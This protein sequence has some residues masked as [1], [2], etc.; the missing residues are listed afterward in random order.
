MVPPSGPMRGLP[1]RSRRN[2]VC[3]PTVPPQLEYAA[4]PLTLWPTWRPSHHEARAEVVGHRG[5]DGPSNPAGGVRRTECQIKC[6]TVDSIICADVLM[7]SPRARPDG[8]S[9]ASA[10]AEPLL[11]LPDDRSHPG[12]RAGHARIAPPSDSRLAAR[13]KGFVRPRI[14]SWG[15]MG[16]PS[17]HRSMPDHAFFSITQLKS[18]GSHQNEC[19]RDAASC[20]RPRHNL[21]NRDRQFAQKR[22]L[23]FVQTASEPRRGT[24]SPPESRHGR[25][26]IQRNASHRPAE[27]Q[28]GDVRGICERTSTIRPSHD[29]AKGIREQPWGKMPSLW[30]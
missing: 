10:V 25:L 14:A 13:P 18:T 7:G 23:A 28:Y 12:G 21:P 1:A 9:P 20:G 4:L 11:A 24:E 5:L 16:L 2:F 29:T 6:S 27:G 22:L 30:R 19:R 17:R 15:A 3:D 26:F 8:G